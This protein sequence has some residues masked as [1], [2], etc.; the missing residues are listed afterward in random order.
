MKPKEVLFGGKRL[1]FC[2]NGCGKLV[3][4]SNRKYCSQECSAE[5]YAKHNQ[6]GIREYVFKREKGKCQ[7]CGWIN[8]DFDLQPPHSPEF[9]IPEPKKPGWV[10][11]G[12]GAHRKAV[13]AY[14]KELAIWDDEYHNYRVSDGYKK[15]Y[16]EYEKAEREYLIKLDEWY[17]TRKW[18]N[19]IADH[20]IPIALGGPEFDLDNVQ[21]LC[22][23]CDKKKT[24][25]DQCKIAR[26]RRLIKNVGKNN[27]VLPI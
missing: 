25:Q 9:S 23:V 20:I 14:K 6:A 17:K 5:F 19:Y 10:E 13:I 12:L 1:R 11:G 16:A 7:G 18:R 8:K 24:K 4:E 26:K 15:A 2:L 3:P 27:G 21:L 22:E